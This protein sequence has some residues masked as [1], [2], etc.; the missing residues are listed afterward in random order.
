MLIPNTGSV[1]L[2]GILSNLTNGLGDIVIELVIF[3]STSPLKVESAKSIGNCP[4]DNT[5][6]TIFK[7]S[8]TYNL[9]PPNKGA[10]SPVVVTAQPAVEL[11]PRAAFKF[12]LMSSAATLSISD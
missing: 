5:L 10:V 9:V 12:V 1:V 7:V 6:F 4:F 8:L 11:V 2:K 3:A